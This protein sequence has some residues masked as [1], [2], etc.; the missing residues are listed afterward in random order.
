VLE[1]ANSASGEAEITPPFRRFTKISIAYG[2]QAN[3]AIDLDPKSQ[4]NDL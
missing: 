1:T 4:G 3:L 2:P